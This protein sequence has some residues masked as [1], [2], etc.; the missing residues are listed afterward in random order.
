MRSPMEY[1]HNVSYGE[2]RLVGLILY[3]MVKK[4][5][6]VF[7]CFD[8]K[9]TDRQTDGQTPDDSMAALPASRAA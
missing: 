5:E 6:N 7:T 2:N 3:Q 4:F 1:C 9:V 8:T